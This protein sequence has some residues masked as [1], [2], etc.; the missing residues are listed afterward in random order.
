MHLVGIG[1]THDDWESLV[2]AIRRHM[3]SGTLT[4]TLLK[5]DDDGNVGV[6][7]L[8]N[9][10]VEIDADVVFFNLH[11]FETPADWKHFLTRSQELNQHHLRWAMIVESERKELSSSEPSRR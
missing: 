1:F 7:V 8:G 9:R 6:E 2:H 3:P 5:S 4:G 10:L 11:A